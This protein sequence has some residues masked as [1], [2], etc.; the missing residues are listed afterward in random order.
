MTIY[1]SDAQ[2][3]IVSSTGVFTVGTRY[4]A[5][6]GVA[7]YSPQIVSVSQKDS[8]E[9]VYFG[10]TCDN[11]WGVDTEW[12]C[13]AAVGAAGWFRGDINFL[14]TVNSGAYGDGHV[15]AEITC[16]AG[17]D[18]CE[19]IGLN[20]GNPAEYSGYDPTLTDGT[21]P[22]AG[23]AI[24]ETKWI[25]GAGTHTYQTGYF[26]AR[27]QGEYHTGSTVNAHFRVNRV[28]WSN[29]DIILWD[30]NSKGILTSNVKYG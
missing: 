5:G 9:L 30:I 21:T 15:D 11:T 13:E 20:S 10:A 28:R 29:G 14:V 4:G 16:Y 23:L 24:G 26:T 6:A 19:L 27:V 17:D 7:T 18:P 2:L 25:L 3:G 1:T 8:H 12:Q 22:D